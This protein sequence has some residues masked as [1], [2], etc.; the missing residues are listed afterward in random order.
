MGYI[1]I[2]RNGPLTYIIDEMKEKIDPRPRCITCR[3]VLPI[4][5]LYLGNAFAIERGYC[6]FSCMKVDLKDKAFDMLVEHIKKN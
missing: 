1:F 2:D 4:K 6:T 5:A 3:E